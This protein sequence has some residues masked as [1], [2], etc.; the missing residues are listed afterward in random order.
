[1]GFAYGT[2]PTGITRRVQQSFEK[3]QTM[4]SSDLGNRIPT[5]LV[6]N[7]FGFSRG[8]AAAR[9][10]VHKVKTQPRSFIGWNLTRERIIVNFVGL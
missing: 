9:H 1:M 10:F 8:A 3:I 4:V 2:G 5:I 7:V 6:L